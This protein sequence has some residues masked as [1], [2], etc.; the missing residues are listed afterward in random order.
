MKGGFRVLENWRGRHRYE[1]QVDSRNRPHG[2]GVMKYDYAIDSSRP[3]A[4][5]AILSEGDFRDGVR[6]GKNVTLFKNGD[7]LET[8]YLQNAPH[9]GVYRWSDDNYYLG[10]FKD[11]KFHTPEGETSTRVLRGSV[12]IGS[13]KEGTR[14]GWRTVVYGNG[15]CRF[16]VLDDLR[17]GEITIF[18]WHGDVMTANY[19]DDNR[20][21]P[22]SYL[23]ANGDEWRG[24]FLSHNLATG[25]KTEEASGKTVSLD[26]E[27]RVEE[28]TG[29][30]EVKFSP[31]KE[32][33]S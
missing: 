5:K 15:H 20:I 21:G 25:I 24:T 22:S 16:S 17:Q 4:S 31:V 7:V 18:F 19:V 11:H 8:D 14:Q 23:W 26:L 27:F 30:W 29:F 32:E 13:W 10:H 12:E 2:K 1:G 6:Q 33:E 3:D 9:H 28:Q